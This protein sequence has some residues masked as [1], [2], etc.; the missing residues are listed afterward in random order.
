VADDE[1]DNELVDGVDVTCDA[2]EKCA[3]GEEVTEV[4]R[5]ST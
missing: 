4:D 5:A 1:G 2:E 3:C